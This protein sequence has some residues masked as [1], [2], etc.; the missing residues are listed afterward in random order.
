MFSAPLSTEELTWLQA[1]VLFE[2]SLVC[3]LYFS[4][5]FILTM[6]FSRFLLKVTL[7]RSL[8]LFVRYGVLH[9]S[10]VDH[11]IAERFIFQS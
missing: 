7:P 11:S 8:N 5:S 1:A 6:N 3:F 4:L 9:G 10:R 2:D